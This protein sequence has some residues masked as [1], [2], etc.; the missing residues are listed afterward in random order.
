MN[1]LDNVIAAYE[2]RNGPYEH[3]KCGYCQYGYSYLDDGDGLPFHTCDEEKLTDDMYSWLK[4]YQHLVQ[5]GDT[6]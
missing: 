5:Q 6:R 2:C 4:I 1:N 3:G